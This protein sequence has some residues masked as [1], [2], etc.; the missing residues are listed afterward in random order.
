MSPGLV[1][2]FRRFHEEHGRTFTDARRYVCEEV[3][4]FRRPFTT[5]DVLDRLAD[6]NDGRRVSRPTIYR[7]LDTLVEAGLL[8]RTEVGFSEVAR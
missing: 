6:R 5:E 1:D 4:L 7:T 8:V 2:R 3:V